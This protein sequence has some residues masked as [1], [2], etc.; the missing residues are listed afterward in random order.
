MVIEVLKDYVYTTTVF[1]AF[2]TAVLGIIVLGKLFQ[3]KLKELFEDKHFF[4]FFFLVAG[5]VLYAMGELTWYLV[6]TVFGEVPPVSMPDFYW[7]SG[8]IVLLIAFVTLALRL[9]KEHGNAKTIMQS[10]LIGVVLIGGIM[11]YMLSIDLVKLAASRGH[12]FI[13][14]FY[15]VVSSLLVVFSAVVLFY[16]HNLERFFGKMVLFL[17]LSNIGILAGDILYLSTTVGEG[18]KFLSV[19]YNLVYTAAYAISSWAFI[20]ALLNASPKK[21]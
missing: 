2:T 11:F 19:L 1:F 17:F 5:Y 13:G 8:G 3:N 7:A 18:G 16:S 4:V 10:L 9:S 6:F 14:F 20:T 12:V 21:E 15:P